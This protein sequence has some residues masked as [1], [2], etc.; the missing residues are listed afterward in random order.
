MNRRGFTLLEILVAMGIL[1]IIILIVSG[2]FHQSRMAFDSGVRK[3]ELNME[4]RSAMNLM[5]SE[6]SRAVADGANSYYTNVISAGGSTIKFWTMGMTTN[7]GRVASYVTYKLLLSGGELVRYVEPVNLQLPY[8]SRT[9]GGL[10]VPLAENVTKL[11]F[12]PSDASSHTTNLPVYF[13]IELEMSKGSQFSSIR[14]W[15]DGPSSNT[16][17]DNINSWNSKL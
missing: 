6:L 17:A 15:S 1:A 7:G 11:Y 12:K 4:G 9:L 5:A 16:A 13:D 3:T 10:D 8:P 14:A 2:I